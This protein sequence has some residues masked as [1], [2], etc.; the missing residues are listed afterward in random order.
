MSMFSS[1]IS[2]PSKKHFTW[3]AD[4]FETEIVS[5]SQKLFCFH[6]SRKWTNVMSTVGKT[7]VLFTDMLDP[8]YILKVIN[9]MWYLTAIFCQ[10]TI[11]YHMVQQLT[12]FIMNEDK[13]QAFNIW[14]HPHNKTSQQMIK[15]VKSPIMTRWKTRPA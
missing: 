1:V 13:H 2:K 9:F 11:R 14:W 12:S 5:F 6:I 8:L 10:T 4:L 15:H 3:K 7:P